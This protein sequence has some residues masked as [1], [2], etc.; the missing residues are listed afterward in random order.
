[1]SDQIPLS[2]Q[3]SALQAELTIRRKEMDEE[4]RRGRM[5]ESAR[6]YTIESLEAA[7]GTLQRLQ[8][9]ARIINQRTFNGDEAPVG[10]CW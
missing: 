7:I 5:K 1:M 8:G 4:V 3:I 6:Q 10:G 9:R 2:R